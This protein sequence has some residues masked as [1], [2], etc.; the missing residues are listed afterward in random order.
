MDNE[1]T[2]IVPTEDELEKYYILKF[3]QKQ[4]DSG[5]FVMGITMEI[6]EAEDDCWRKD[7]DGTQSAG[8]LARE[9]REFSTH[10]PCDKDNP[11]HT[12]LHWKFKCDKCGSISAHR[13]DWIRW[14]WFDDEHGNPMP[15]VMRDDKNS[16]HW[17][18][19]GPRMGLNQLR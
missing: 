13:R 14:I 10:V 15:F 7:C 3:G 5:E 1:N 2:L 12:Y 17:T 19:G 6:S 4:F 9:S 16:L 11:S 18:A 8:L